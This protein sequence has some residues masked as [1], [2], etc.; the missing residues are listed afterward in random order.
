VRTTLTLED[1]LAD[2]LKALA[3]RQRKPFKQVVNEV[4]RRG[5]ASTVPAAP[6]Q[7]FSVR[8]FRSAFQPGVDPEKLN[9]RIDELHA[10]EALG[11]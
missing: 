3:E 2:K 7:P 6:S 4:V 10:R 1:D 8:P 11:S 9:Q 5:L